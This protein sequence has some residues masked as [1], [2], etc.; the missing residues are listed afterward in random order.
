MLDILCIGDSKLDVFLHIPT[1]NPFIN[2]DAE[3][4]ELMVK[5]GDKINVEKYV[6]DIGGN[7]SNTAVGMA[8]L[9]LDVGLCAETGNDEFS[10]KILNRLREEKINT[11]RLIQTK[12]QKSSFSVILSYKGDR[13][14]F[15][16]DIKREH[17][18]NLDNIESKFI[19][20]TSLGEIW[21]ETY[22]KVFEIVRSTGAKL[23]FNPGVLQITKKDK[24]VLDIIEMTDYLF[25]NK[26]EAEELLY[27][28]ELNLE[29]KDD[30]NLIK[31]L[32][33]GLKSMGA[34]N[35]I[36]TDGINGSYIEDSV[37]NFSHLGIVKAELIEQTGAGDAY[38]AGFLAAVINDL[39][40]KEAMKWGALNSSSVIQ[41]V[42]AQEGLLTKL[43][44]GAK[45]KELTD[46]Q[47][48]AI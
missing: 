48:Q 44:L 37:N 6:F 26:Q 41:K 18:F 32:L 12:N 21:E 16:E 33:F 11:D 31:R 46:L 27:G 36:I 22:G 47:P 20:L 43:E 3:K 40:V 23:A 9:G 5:Y 8:R 25:V 4:K 45:L 2:L 13:T 14:I 29:I 10:Q 19:Y 42:G 30:K 1:D 15:Q 7:A 28:K 24:Y 34:K 35:V 38:T 17:K 39:P